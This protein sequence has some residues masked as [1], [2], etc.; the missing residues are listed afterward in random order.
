MRRR[1]GTGLTRT[2]TNEV[3]AEAGVRDETKGQAFLQG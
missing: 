3:D 1:G 2:E